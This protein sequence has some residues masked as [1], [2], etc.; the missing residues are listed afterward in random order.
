[1]NKRIKAAVFVAALAATNVI[2]A[3]IAFAKDS[4]W[5]GT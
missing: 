3:G 4:G 1:M 5:N 2:T